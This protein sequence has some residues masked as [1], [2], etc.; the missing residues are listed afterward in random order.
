MSGNSISLG[1]IDQ[2]LSPYYEADLQAG[3]TSPD[4]ARELLS[5]VSVQEG[6]QLALADCFAH[7]DEYGRVHRR[8]L[9]AGEVR[10]QFLAIDTPSGPRSVLLSG[11]L[12]RDEEGEP[13]W[14]DGLLVDVTAAR[15]G[16]A[17]REVQQLRA[18]LLFMGLGLLQ[19]I[20]SLAATY[21]GET[22]G[23]TSTNALR[24]DLMASEEYAARVAG[25]ASQDRAE[26]D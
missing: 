20:V 7:A 8:L 23:W 13:A 25:H 16:A 2:V 6:D 5:L 24:A 10:D 4:R 19:Q 12:I 21:F 9:E 22:V 1:R 17:D 3:K 14:I 15:G 11:V 26:E 18:S